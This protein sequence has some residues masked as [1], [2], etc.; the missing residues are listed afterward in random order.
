MGGGR[1]SWRSAAGAAP[2]IAS[3]ASSASLVPRRSGCARSARS[4]SPFVA[5]PDSHGAPEAAAV[6]VL[7]RVLGRAAHRA[8]QVEPRHPVGAHR[9]GLAV[10]ARSSSDSIGALREKHGRTRTAPC[11]CRRRASGGGA[12]PGARRGRASRPRR[13]RCALIRAPTDSVGAGVQVAEVV[14]VKVGVDGRALASGSGLRQP[15][16]IA[17]YASSMLDALTARH[18]GDD[19]VVAPAARARG[20][21]LRRADRPPAPRSL[22]GRRARRRLAA[23]ARARCRL[24]RRSLRA[25]RARPVRRAPPGR[26][27]PLRPRCGTAPPG[28]AGWRG[29]A[30]RVIAD[31][32]ETRDAGG[33]AL[34]SGRGEGE[35]RAAGLLA[36][37]AARRWRARA[38]RRPVALPALR[39]R[40]R[41]AQGRRRARRGVRGRPRRGLEAELVLAGDGPLAGSLR[42]PG[43]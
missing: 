11:P 20:A 17:R 28:R 8:E 3:V 27:P 42:A 6:A 15:R 31:S 32:E 43:V 29:G 37:A 33:R 7:H 12:R 36:P 16:G 2:S 14:G 9:L 1:R 39:G 34:G 30:A 13:L 10:D 21:R 26:L 22:A 18:P 24:P 19:W 35:R 41:A 5:R 23:R 4:S 38:P 40:P 25:H